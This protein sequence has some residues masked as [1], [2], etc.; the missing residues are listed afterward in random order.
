[1]LSG[2]SITELGPHARVATAVAPFVFSLVFR[3][4]LGNCRT[5]RWMISLGTV[6][7]AVNVLMAP[8]SIGIRHD[9]GNWRSWLP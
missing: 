4:I 1:M 6:W 7:F 8:Y 2:D 3:L 5:T 9:V